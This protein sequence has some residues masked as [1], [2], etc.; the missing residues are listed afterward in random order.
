MKLFKRVLVEMLVISSIVVC[1]FTFINKD[2]NKDA[3]PLLTTTNQTVEQ[4]EK[5]QEKMDVAID[6]KKEI[7]NEKLSK[8]EA[9]VTRR[10]ED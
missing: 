6:I 9:M 5:E 10:S 4:I 7:L 8:A 2:N 1:S 3:T